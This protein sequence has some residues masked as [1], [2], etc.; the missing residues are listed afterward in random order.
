MISDIEAYRLQER[1]THEL[2]Q[3]LSAIAT[4]AHACDK[5]LDRTDPNINEIQSA[6]RQIADQAARAGDIIRKLCSL[7]RNEQ[8][9]HLPFD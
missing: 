1:L 4:Y 7:A 9:T 8:S 6:L 3:P 2:N 5:L